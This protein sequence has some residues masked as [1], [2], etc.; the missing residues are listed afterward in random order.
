MTAAQIVADAAE[1]STIRKY[2][3]NRPDGVHAAAWCDGR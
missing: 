1:D 3:R 2:R